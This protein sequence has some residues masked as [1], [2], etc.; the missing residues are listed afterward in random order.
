MAICAKVPSCR[1]IFFCW[2]HVREPSRH[3]KNTKMFRSIV[4]THFLFYAIYSKSTS[5][6]LRQSVSQDEHAGL[7]PVEW[8]RHMVSER[9]MS[10]DL[11]FVVTF[12]S[13]E[14]WL[15]SQPAAFVAAASSSVD[16]RRKNLPLKSATF[17]GHNH[18]QELPRVPPFT[19]V[20]NIVK[21]SF[22]RAR[23]ICP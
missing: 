12:G 5:E 6:V 22:L 9:N 20:N 1:S 8:W 15:K 23:S 19:T 2:A 17:T 11:T 16:G 3:N 21:Q 7:T 18:P 13:K 14:K 10:H 4:I